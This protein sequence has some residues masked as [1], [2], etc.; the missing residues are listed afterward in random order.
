MI[1]NGECGIFN[2]VLL[3]CLQD[4]SDRLVE[5][6][7]INSFGQDPYKKMKGVTEE[8]M[9]HEELSTSA[10]TLTLLENERIK[11]RFY[12]EISHEIQFE[13]TYNPPLLMVYDF[14]ERKLGLDEITVNPADD[15]KVRTLF[16]EETLERFRQVV[17]STTPEKV[18]FD[19][20]FEIPLGGEM[21]MV[22]ATCRTL[23]SEDTGKHM[24]VIGKL[25]DITKEHSAMCALRHK[26]THDGLTMLYNSETGREKIIKKLEDAETNYLMLM[27]DLDYFKT[28]NDNYG[29]E[30]GNQV[31]K[32]IASTLKT[33]LR[34]DDIIARFGGDEFLVLL[35]GHPTQEATVKRIFSLL[36]QPFNSM[37]ISVSMGVADTK[38]CGRG[39]TTL[40]NCADRAAYEAKNS[41]KNRFCYFS[42]EL[43]EEF[44]SLSSIEDDGTSSGIVKLADKAQLTNFLKELRRIFEVIRVYD[45]G[46]GKKYKAET[47]G[48]LKTTVGDEGYRGSA[49]SS[50]GECSLMTRSRASG[51]VYRGN[52][53]YKQIAYYVEC[54]RGAYVVEITVPM[55]EEMLGDIYDKAQLIGIIDRK[56]GKLYS[57]AGTGTFNKQ[58][59][60]EQLGTQT[61]FY[62]LIVVNFDGSDNVKSSEVEKKIAECLSESVR[63]TDAVV[64]GD[65]NKFA[66]ILKSLTVKRFDAILK[67]IKNSMKEVNAGF[68]IGALRALGKISDLIERT[69]E[70]SIRAM[71][72]ND[73]LV[74]EKERQNK[75]GK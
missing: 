38:V 41:G 33:G 47:D 13:L 62:S 18:S 30:F 58:Y 68:G 25:V 7:K 59:F 4:I 43:T 50:V 6:L 42:D 56:G 9:Q 55:D 69:D 60:D 29:H 1:I 8:I 52:E 22:R 73:H 27:V 15:E 35:E 70:F 3:E 65:G 11:N 49:R 48:T 75:K 51:V 63:S 72:E 14:G 61:D 39:F 67:N 53:L 5:E 28:I 44:T 12:A 64:H 26:A 20:D 45:V 57:D 23:F 71:S 10:R 36:T 2:P 24:G 17:A 46:G 40:F 66:V 19:M 32:H 21:R 16:G 54:D 37:P 34:R 31:L 74:Y